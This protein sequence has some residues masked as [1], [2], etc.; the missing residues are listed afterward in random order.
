MPLRTRKENFTVL[1]GSLAQCS[2]PSAAYGVCVLA[3][4]E[5][6]KKG[7][8]EVEFAEMQK[9]IS[10]SVRISLFLGSNEDDTFL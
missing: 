10:E 1:V 3:N 5:S 8:C 4:L 7:S 2:A 9:C 6:L